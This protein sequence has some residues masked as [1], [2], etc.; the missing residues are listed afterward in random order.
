M[1]IDVCLHTVSAKRGGTPSSARRNPVDRRPS[2][3]HN[4]TGRTTHRGRG[5]RSKWF[6]NDLSTVCS[7][8]GLVA[9]LRKSH[10]S[11]NRTAF[12]RAH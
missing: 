1:H 3:S 4:T 5:S 10:G 12:P 6:C 7:S 8:I 9:F 11:T 2:G